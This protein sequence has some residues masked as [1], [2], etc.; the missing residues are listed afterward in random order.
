MNQKMYV[1]KDVQSILEKLSSHGFQGVLVGGCVR[2][3]LLNKTPKDYD[4]AT[5]A[6][7]LQLM[8]LFEKNSPKGIE[9]GTV[10]VIEQGHPYEVTTFRS[11]GEYKDGRHPESVQFVQT[12]EEDLKRRDFTINAMAYSLE[13]GLLDPLKGREDLQE[14]IIRAVGDPK[15]RMKEDALRMLRAYRF[16][17]RLNFS[18]DPALQDAI[19]SQAQQ[20]QKVAV[21]RVV[22]EVEEILQTNPLLIYEMTD[23]LHPWIPFLEQMKQMPQNSPYHYGDVLTHTLDALDYLKSYNHDPVVTWALFFHDMGKLYT[24]TTDE[25]GDHFKGHCEVSEKIAK[26]LVQDLKFSNLMR[27][28]IPLLVKHHDSFYKPTL[29]NIYKLRVE[30]NWSDTFLK[31][32]FQLQRADI[33]AHTVHDRQK[34]LDAFIQFY[35]KEKE[36]RPISLRDLALTGND[37]KSLGFVGKEIKEMLD[38]C[39]HHVF[40]TPE[41]NQTEKLYQ[42]I[43]KGKLRAYKKDEMKKRN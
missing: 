30:R 21:E 5:S 40:F 9:H 25:K 34:E 7:P 23:L 6:T 24:K 26:K 39:L 28:E 11:D 2:D 27:K 3:W 10:I 22:P 31:K 17:A 1:P 43:Q 19:H 37:L 14:K 33:Y 38:T 20:L 35:E 12:V 16:A 8:N 36:R 15:I 41:D 32:L 29:K 18:I 13:E 4:M 42:L